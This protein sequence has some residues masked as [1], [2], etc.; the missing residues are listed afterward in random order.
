VFAFPFNFDLTDSE[1]RIRI[2]K[3]TFRRLPYTKI[4]EVVAP[5]GRWLQ[6]HF[7]LMERWTSFGSSKYIIIHRSDTFLALK[8]I[9]IINPPD[10]DT[11]VS[12]L[13]GKIAA[14]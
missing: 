6:W 14:R 8:R 3:W 11:F 4:R 1:L 13:R 10:R 12:Q 2:G 5:D 7:G 9:L